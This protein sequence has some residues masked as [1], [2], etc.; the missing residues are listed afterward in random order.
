MNGVK[1]SGIYFFRDD[2]E[3]ILT[4]IALEYVPQGVFVYDFM[5]PI[6]D[7]YGPHL[8]YSERLKKNSFIGKGEM[9]EDQLVDFVLSSPEVISTFGRELP[10]SLEDFVSL[11]ESRPIRNPN[12]RLTYSS[13][14]FL[15]GDYES[16]IK[17]LEGLRDL[18][19]KPHQEYYDKFLLGLKDGSESAN[20][21]LNEAKEKN[22]QSFGLV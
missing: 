22:M 1:K 5:F 21:L 17:S 10:L 16:A 19:N 15:L 18:L 12:L 2:F 13:A 4:G 9:S 8:T 20:I 11:F 3:E 6:F 7:F 14:L